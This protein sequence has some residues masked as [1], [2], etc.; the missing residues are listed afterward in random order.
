MIT[1]FKSLSIEKNKRTYSLGYRTNKVNILD[2]PDNFIVI[3]T[4]FSR[5]NFKDKLLSRGC[6]G[7]VRKYPHTP[8]IDVSG[9]VIH[10]KSKKF[11]IGDLVYSLATPFGI[12]T[13]GGYSE[14]IISHEK[15]FYMC[16]SI[17]TPYNSMCIGTSGFTAAIIAYKLFDHCKTF[18]T[19]KSCI[20][21]GSK[22]SI[23]YFLIPLLR[24]NNYI[25]DV[26]CK[27][28][29]ITDSQGELVR[30]YYDLDYLTRASFSLMPQKW[31]YGIDL[32]GGSIT[33]AIC[34]SLN[35]HGC[36][37]SV[38]NVLESSSNISLLPFFLRG[39]S[40]IGIN[41]ESSNNSIRKE[42]LHLIYNLELF[43]D[44]ANNSSLVSFSN[45]QSLL[46]TNKINYTNNP[47]I[48]FSYD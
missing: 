18:N 1:E 23:G 47:V 10:S 29:S 16:D 17:M 5:V 3:K 28:E 34:A 45:L 21:T 48:Y 35:N 25:I 46:E 11:K 31:S 39:I 2:I 38:G 13:H 40:I 4:H 43:D 15:Y 30:K 41:A 42:A 44:L 7:L 26:C 33:S 20:L 27:R 9:E 22:S 14:L 6:P 12:E 36:L 19:Q 8:G 32:F 24:Q 37:F